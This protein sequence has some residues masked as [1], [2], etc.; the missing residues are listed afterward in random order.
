[1][2]WT[3]DLTH[4]LV[5]SQKRCE[6]S[7]ACGEK[8]ELDWDFFSGAEALSLTEYGTY[9][10]QLI[11]YKLCQINSQKG[12]LVRLMIRRIAAPTRINEARSQLASHR[13]LPA[14]KT[15]HGI[16]RLQ[17]RTSQ[18][19]KH[20]GEG[21]H[22]PAVAHAIRGFELSGTSTSFSPH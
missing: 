11:T 9:I 6:L 22:K 19:D 13:Y 21:N 17:S 5:S 15:S 18:G 12:A 14:V 7:S 3:E 2:N 16:V 8:I 10:N 4:A 20:N 1:M